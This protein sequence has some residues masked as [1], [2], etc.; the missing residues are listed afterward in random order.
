M[1]RKEP[2]RCECGCGAGNEKPAPDFDTIS[3][4]F[5]V[6]YWDNG[7]FRKGEK[8]PQEGKNGEDFLIGIVSSA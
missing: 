6:L 1:G 2:G 4:L 3:A 8:G 5:Q 7:A